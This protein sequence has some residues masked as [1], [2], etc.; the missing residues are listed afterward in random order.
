ME[1]IDI[2][3]VGS[4]PAGISAALNAKIRNKTF[5][6]FGTKEISPK[7]AKAHQINN[8]LGFKN[9]DASSLAYDMYE[10]VINLGVPIKTEKVI[11]VIDG[12]EKIVKTE[13]NEYKTKTILIACGRVE[14]KL[15]ILKEHAL[16]IS[17][18]A[19]C[20]GSLYNGKDVMLIGNNKES[21]NDA[22][23][24]SNIVNSLIYVNYSDYNVTFDK[25]NI[26]VIN[27][28]ISNLN[29]SDEIIKTVTI[30]DKEYAID[31]LFI[32]NGYT[33]NIDFIKSLNIKLDNNYIV[34][35][36][37]MKTNIDGIYASGDIIKKKVYQIVTAASDGAIAALSIIKDLK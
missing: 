31:G 34:V 33:P 21:E 7:L 22:I 20:D 11:D 25:D 36:E 32:E 10:Q 8:Y 13:K 37:N 14:K 24:L 15:D 16:N 26:K 30:D 27:K 23:Y 5:K 6:V 2:A 28:K 3:I 35:D 12:K 18:C 9:I 19:K 29:V 17:Y 1:R 4:G